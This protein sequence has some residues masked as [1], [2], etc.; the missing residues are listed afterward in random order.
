MPT[1]HDIVAQAE[2]KART[3]SRRLGGEERLKDLLFQ[4]R[5]NAGAVVPYFDDHLFAACRGIEPVFVSL[6]SNSK[7]GRISPPGRI[8]TL[9]GHVI[10]TWRELE[11]PLG[12]SVEVPDQARKRKCGE[13]LSIWAGPSMSDTFRRL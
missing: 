8:S 10:E 12:E 5:R 4:F 1:G 13:Q 3:F 2:S 6:I 11:F 7:R 9:Y